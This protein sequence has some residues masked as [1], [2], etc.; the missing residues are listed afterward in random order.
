LHNADRAGL[1]YVLAG[2]SLL[3]VGDA[4]VK[5]MAGMWPAPAM[6]GIRYLVGAIL[7]AVLLARREGPGA[8]AVP[9]SRLQWVRG[10][11]ISCSAMGMWFA[12]WIM[13]LAEATTIGFTQPMITALLAI[14]L[15]REPSHRS[16][17]IAI[18]V[19]F[20]GVVIVLRPN[21]SEVGFGALFPLFAATGMAVTIIANRATVGKASVLL[22]QY[23]MSITA[24]I[25]L[26]A[27]SLVG[28]LSGAAGFQLSWPPESVLARCVFIG[29]SAT[30]GQYLIY[31][32]TVRAGPAT[33][34]PMTYGQLLVAVAL[35]WIFFGE[36][37]DATAM[38]GAAVIVGA[39][40]Y[41]WYS[42][43]RPKNVG[44]IAQ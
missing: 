18:A 4:I 12:V 38:I 25:F 20:I 1:L 11:A 33:V 32:G 30:L 34:A 2:F 28:H 19:A 35:G 23:W 3:S 13:P 10:I 9:R 5:G 37:P 29:F 43:R 15:L 40:L 6:I 42:S 27:V 16:T 7:L 44:E 22:A 8:L 39:G 31:M 24:L 21:F 41:L 36:G 17:W 14:V 26:T